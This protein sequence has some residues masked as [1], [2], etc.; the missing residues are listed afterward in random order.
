MIMPIYLNLDM[1][2]AYQ[3]SFLNHNI[4]VFKLGLIFGRKLER[5]IHKHQERVQLLPTNE[6]C[7]NYYIFELIKG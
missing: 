4:H 7:I 5:M 6:S 1:T 2:F 3:S